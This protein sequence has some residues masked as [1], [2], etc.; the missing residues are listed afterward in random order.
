MQK[1][2]RHATFT[3][4]L[5]ATLLTTGTASAIEAGGVR[6]DD[7][8]TLGG[9]ELIA[10]G[11]GTRTKFVFDVY[12][13]ALY[14]PA[15]ANSAEA[16]AAQKSP[17]RIALQLLRDV[18]AADFVEALRAGIQAN[19]SE[20]EYLALKPQIE[21]FAA[22]LVAVKEVSKGT[23]VLIDYLPASGTRMT[24]AGQIRG[25][26]IPGDA[27]YDALLKIWLGGK[28]VQADL[29]TKLLGK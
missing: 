4:G 29:K 1:N 18:G 21:Q 23:P 7:R 20:A 25:K 16:V 24:I 15:R 17:R 6:F 28:P 5:I 22:T 14:L 12:A 10:N 2:L 3:L 19:L 13:M 11:A 27:F 9:S 8:I 26:D